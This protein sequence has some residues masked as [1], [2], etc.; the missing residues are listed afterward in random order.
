MNRPVFAL[1]SILSLASATAL[2]QETLSHSDLA[3]YTDIVMVRTSAGAPS[4]WKGSLSRADVLAAMQAA[5]ASH[6]IAEGDAL[7]YP[8]PAPVALEAGAPPAAMSR[9]LGGPSSADPLTIDGYRFVGGEAGYVF[10]G[11]AR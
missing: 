10:V 4:Y 2:A 7:G 3:P 5:R 1:V 9:V 8:Y 11:R 6:T